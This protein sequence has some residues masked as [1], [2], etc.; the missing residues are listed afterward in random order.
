MMRILDLSPRAVC[1]TDNGSTY[2]IYH[3][4]RELARRHE[5]RQFSQPLLGQIRRP[6][7]AT[8][9]WPSASYREH[10][11]PSLIAATAAEWCHRS[12]FRQAI[13]SGA[14]LQLTR[15][16]LLREW[17]GWANV[18]LVEF[19]WQFAYCRRAAPSL[20]LVLASHNV[21]ISTRISNGGAAGVAVQRSPVIRYVRHLEEHA[22]TRADLILA[23]SDA[24]R[25]ELVRRY[26]VDGERVVTVPNGADT[27]GL[28]PVTPEARRMLRARLRLPDRTTVVYLAAGPKV[29]DVE[30]LKWVRRVARRHRDLTFMIV[31]GVCPAPF[32][33]DNVIATGFV[34]DHRPYLQAADISLNPIE[35]G[36]GTK[37]KVFDGLAAGLATVVFA[38]AVRGTSLKNGEHVLVV[39]KNEGALGRA[40]RGL[41]DEPGAAS[42][43]ARTG[44]R[45]VC[46]RHDWKVIARHLE[47]ALAGLL[48]HAHMP[49]ATPN[50]RLARRA[51]GETG[52]RA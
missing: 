18:A 31:G 27:D 30:G 10:R 11:N 47:T 4:L 24:D 33:A 41:V 44:R 14:C 46:D 9:V 36:G 6:G 16:R 38:E 37:L 23:V 5:V 43:L 49:T 29:P 15:P 7:F 13:F 2:R 39:E 20:P 34:D 21:E 17:F 25:E 50:H 8:D 12:W 3:L 28:F 45:F 35:Y 51:A 52:I 26:G 48:E 40:I 42:A 22:V 1:P 32:V 19:P